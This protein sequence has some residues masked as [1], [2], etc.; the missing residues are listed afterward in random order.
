MGDKSDEVVIV[1]KDVRRGTYITW[2]CVLLVMAV[3]L[4]L[5]ETGPDKALG[6]AL[7]VGGTAALIPLA[8]ASDKL[9][10]RLKLRNALRAAAARDQQGK[11]EAS[12][13]SAEGFERMAPQSV[14]APASRGATRGSSTHLPGPDAT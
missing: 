11:P 14:S 7:I 3:A 5:L 9:T 12:H 10:A 2:G 13:T 1:D 4:A 8:H 6:I